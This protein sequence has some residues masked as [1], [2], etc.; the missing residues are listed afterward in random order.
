M[1]AQLREWLVRLAPEFV[2]LAEGMHKQVVYLPTSAIG[3]PP[4]RDAEQG[5]LMVR[6]RNVHPQWVA[7]PVLYALAKWSRE[8]L[9]A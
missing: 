8:G 7:A 6:P 4:E 3:V 1:S 9:G 5:L 2:T